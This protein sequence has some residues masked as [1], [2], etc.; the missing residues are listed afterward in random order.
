MQNYSLKK[1]FDSSKIDELNSELDK[2]LDEYNG[3]D[4]ETFRFKLA[5]KRG[6][7][8]ISDILVKNGCLYSENVI[9]TK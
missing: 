1:V 9:I 3:P 6:E 7:C 8:T 4:C 2:R 5:D